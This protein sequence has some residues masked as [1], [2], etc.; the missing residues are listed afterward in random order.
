MG[1]VP[2][3]I[4]QE[5]PE[6]EPHSEDLDAE[7]EVDGIVDAKP[8]KKR[9]IF[10]NADKKYECPD[11]ECT[12]S[13]SRAEHLYRHQLNHQPKRIY[14]CDF[15]S[16]SRSFVRADLCARH[17]DRHT[18]KGSH[19]QR[20]DAFKLNGHQS[21]PHVSSAISPPRRTS[22]LS[23]SPVEISHA[24]VRSSDIDPGATATS[25]DTRKTSTTSSDRY[26]V[27]PP[28]SHSAFE[29]SG[30]G[31]VDPQL[32][33]GVGY[34][35]YGSFS[36]GNQYSP[37]NGSGSLMS[38]R[39][40][41]YDGGYRQPQSH[42]GYSSAQTVTMS[43]MQPPQ[44]A[45]PSSMG[46]SLTGPGYA[47][48]S[49]SQNFKSPP[50][51]SSS[52]PSLPSFGFPQS[53]GP[54]SSS[55]LSN[56]FVSAPGVTTFD[57]NSAPNSCANSSAD[58]TSLDQSM[59]GFAMP[60]FGNDGFNRSPPG[61]INE[62]FLASLFG[63]TPMDEM[64]VAS[65]PPLESTA[66][67]Q[68]TTSTLPRL[69][70]EESTYQPPKQEPWVNA[71]FSHGLD[72]NIREST[73]SES[74]RLRLLDIMTTRFNDKE[75]DKDR[76]SRDEILAGDMSQ[77]GHVFS[78]HM[79]KT[80]FTSF[81]VHI[82]QQMPMLHRPTF[83]TE[84]CPDLMLF[85]MICLGASCLERSHPYELT[86]N[87]A[88]LSFFLAYHVR[89]EIFKDPDFRPTAKLWTFQTM[90]FLELY[91][92]MYS[93]RSLHERAHIHHATTLVVMRRGS[94]LIGRSANESP[95]TGPD[96]TR[97]P[98]GPDG[99]INASG[100][101]TPDATWNRW[102]T[103]EAT[104]RTAFAAFII[105]STHATLFGHS[106]IMSPHDLKLP[107][108][109][110]E[111]LWAA[112]S[113]AEVQR[114]EASLAANGFKP[115]S[116]LD[117][118][119][120]TLNGQKVRTNT[121]GRAILMAGLLNISWHMNQRDLQVSS[122]G[123]LNTLG[124]AIKWRAP[125]TRAFDAWRRD[126][127]DSLSNSETWREACRRPND[128]SSLEHRDS[129]FE[130]RT[131]LHSLAHMAMHVDF[132][133]CT[134]FA[135][136]EKALGRIVTDADRAA[137]QRRMRESWAPSARARDAV[138]YALRF[139]CDVLIP[140]DEQVYVNHDSSSN[141]TTTTTQRPPRPPTFTYS[142]RYDNLLSR[143]W[144]L[145]YATLVVWAYGYALDGPLTANLSNRTT[146]HATK[147]PTKTTSTNIITTNPS[148]QATDPTALLPTIQSQIQDM[149]TYLLRL[150]GVASPDDLAG[151]KD[152]N[153]C[154]GLLLLVRGVF[155]QP[156]WELLHEARELL[157]GCFGLLLGG[158]KGGGKGD[159]SGGGG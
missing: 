116:F 17:R 20:K 45:S 56:S 2:P 5:L 68:S 106:A 46:P 41:S 142:A 120:R 1:D 10:K 63:I 91:E 134:V 96:P 117:G 124:T 128:R 8:K 121:F 84:T 29:M 118:L 54:S 157:G 32:S 95:T 80:Y 12:K 9:R 107:L 148:N 90:L 151:L 7:H 123:A 129:V 137:V 25:I 136:S 61:V 114:V 138:F 102:I 74:K 51:F 85:A 82:H 152:R 13:Y 111:A 60:V 6:P 150:G 62:D 100:Q 48:S 14:R 87:S 73:I 18:A 147:T 24:F 26:K 31:M 88:E 28:S 125:L 35:N 47:S 133:D 36:N 101:N 75:S 94:S 16:C 64:A 113:S 58:F 115:T 76:K 3:P 15:P 70:P 72:I 159:E 122:L 98:P 21:T 103:A 49:P 126:F 99:S 50:A 119:K 92:K 130:S 156:R 65:P 104:R 79:L 145:F 30:A 33:H 27:E 57:Q 37:Y 67:N 39:R 11:P 38:D 146:D 53:H 78:L 141:A 105:D 66:D 89:W 97:T 93:T 71:P 86:Q 153:A 83:N 149:Q 140:E 59:F 158:R 23:D 69:E 22:T 81:W 52:L 44:I 42:N 127:D 109:C 110:D 108:P 131:C 34:N 132:I 155:E 77:P 143:P 43:T 139:L 55:I 135:G 19:L 112:T 40:F 144:I 4:D 154:L